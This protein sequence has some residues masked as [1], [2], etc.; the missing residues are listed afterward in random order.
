VRD[1]GEYDVPV[2]ALFVLREY[3]REVAP[4]KLKGAVKLTNMR[5]SPATDVMLVGALGFV[6]GIIT[7][8]TDD[9][10]LTYCAVWA[11]TLNVYSWPFVRFVTVAL[12]VVPFI[13]VAVWLP[14]AV[15]T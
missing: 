4:P 13:V 9:A 10:A 3:T 1:T 7:S 12:R 5:A 6:N 11:S 15:T 8:E 14:L 2:P